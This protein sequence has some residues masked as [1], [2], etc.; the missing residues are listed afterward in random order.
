[1]KLDRCKRGVTSGLSVLTVAFYFVVLAPFCWAQ[2][3]INDAAESMGVG[4]KSRFASGAEPIAIQRTKIIP[5]TPM[6][7]NSTMSNIL[8]S[9]SGSSFG[10]ILARYDTANFG[11]FFGT[12][13]LPARAPSFGSRVD[14]LT[15]LDQG[16]NEV[17]NI[18]VERM[19]P[20]RLS[21][22]FGD[23]Q[24]RLLT[25]KTGDSIRTTRAA[26]ATQIDIALERCDFDRARET[27]RIENI[28]EKVYLRGKVKSERTSR[29]LENVLSINFGGEAVV[30]ELA[31]E[32]TDDPNVD[33][34][35][36]S[37]QSKARDTR[38]KE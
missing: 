32:G 20:P 24:T 34:F 1:M 2:T 14:A 22:D 38:V 7:V 26:L 16:D 4:M 23:K 6:S 21:I 9:N 3:D 15:D 31:V 35:G 5:G 25:T 13:A 8:T 30:N 28:G 36:H 10:G 18:E 12:G 37:I 17:E 29:L 11:K 33:V 27:V 19:Y